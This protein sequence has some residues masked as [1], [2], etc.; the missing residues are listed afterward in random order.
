MNYSRYYVLIIS[1]LLVVPS[2]AQS[3]EYAGRLTSDSYL[4]F[5]NHTPFWLWAN[6][7]GQVP[8][9]AP[10]I[11]SGELLLNGACL[12]NEGKSVYAGARLFGKNKG[13]SFTATELFGGFS[14]K[15]VFI[16][17]GSYA[18]SLIQNGLS[19]SNGNLLNSR[20]ARP[21]PRIT[22]GTN[23]FIKTGIG[24]LKI[25]GRWEEGVLLDE[26]IIDKPRIHHKNL[27]L[28]WGKTEKTTFTFGIDHYA[29]WGGESEVSGK[30]PTSFSE[31]LRT[32][33]ALKGGAGATSSDQENV[34]GNSLGQYFFIFR[35]NYSHITAEFRVVHPFE[36]KSGMVMF[37]GRDNLYSI[38]ITQKEGFGLKHILGEFVYTKNQ[39]G[40]DKRT[41]DGV[42]IHTNG[43]DNYLNH[44]FYHSGFTYF[45][46]VMGS[47]LFYPVVFNDEGISTGISNNR[48][49]AF[50]VGLDGNINAALQW[51][52]LLTQS[53]N[54]G[55]YAKEFDPARKQFSG[56]AQMSFSPEGKHFFGS[57]KLGID[58][59]ENLQNGRF[60][61]NAGAALELGWRFGNY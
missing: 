45:G 6:N 8:G 32:I 56:L 57:I 9:D 37:N 35:K 11:Q 2:L 15:K 59:G 34:A 28:R 31:Y 22:V 44:G 58:K 52:L 42:Y 25:F 19:S 18:D 61:W 23:D 40:D 12:F 43:H 47:P 36:D 26:R 3:F 13:Q 33:L 53:F 54:F 7:L 39:S 49:M 14:I 20:N 51:K 48:L 46:K 27:F 21:Y 60:K 55:T 16:Q 1:L 24:N 29:F 5:N 50:H 38:Y 17:V 30:Q 41:P 4:N 10:F